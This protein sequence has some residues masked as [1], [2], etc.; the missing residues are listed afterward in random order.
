MAVLLGLFVALAYGSSDFIGGLVSKRRPVLEVVASTQ[1]IGTL[2]LGGAMLVTAGRHEPIGADLLRGAGSGLCVTVGLVLLFRGLAAGAMSVVAP[3]TAVGAAVVPFAW[4]LLRGERPGTLAIVGAVVAMGAVVLVALPDASGRAV[5]VPAKEVLLA[6][7]AGLGFGGTFVLLGD[8]HSAS[9][10]WPVLVSKL[11]VSVLVTGVAVARGEAPRLGR[12]LRVIAVGAALDAFANA[13][14]L[15]ATRTSLVSVVAV[16]SSLYP[17][18]TLLL[19][20]VVLGERTARVQRIGL[21]L[22]LGGVL[23]LAT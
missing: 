5:A 1:I 21:A 20:R 2:L 8:T 9:G 14:Y 15:L 18:G 6:V 12:H 19:A 17:A 22:S 7:V 23:L 13:T 3:I 11:T 10:L 16:V 4:A